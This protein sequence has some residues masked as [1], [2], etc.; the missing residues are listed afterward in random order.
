MHPLT[1]VIVEDL[2]AHREALIKLLNKVAPD[3]QI[4]AKPENVKDAIKDILNH[5]PDIVFLDIELGKSSGFEVLE[6]IKNRNFELIITTAFNQYH[7]RA[8]RFCLLR[9]LLKPIDATLLAEAITA[10]RHK[11]DVKLL[12]DKID[13]LLHNEKHTDKEICISY[14]SIV[15]DKDKSITKVSVFQKVRLSDIYLIVAAKSMCRVYLTQSFSEKHQGTNEILHTK[16]L[17]EYEEDLKEYGFMRT[18]KSNIVNLK[19]VDRIEGNTVYFKPDII[20][21]ISGISIPQAHV[22]TLREMLT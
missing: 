17:R 19:H 18:D 3:I 7:E 16:L 13:A 6:A 22:K 14:D 1:A 20:S 10:A 8:L 15:V 4:A 12:H 5:N 9:Y 2:K 21:D 11:T